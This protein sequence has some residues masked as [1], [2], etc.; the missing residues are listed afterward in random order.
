[1]GAGGATSE[2]IQDASHKQSSLGIVQSKSTEL[3]IDETL[4]QYYN[5]IHTRNNVRANTHSVV[6]RSDSE[7]NLT[8]KHC[9][10]WGWGN[11]D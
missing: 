7:S 4:V 5:D 10:G 11:S 9:V 1:V 2:C 8:N 3:T 6:C